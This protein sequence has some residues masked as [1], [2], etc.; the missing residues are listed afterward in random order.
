VAA[1]A[2]WHDVARTGWYVPVSTFLLGVGLYGSTSRICLQDMRRHWRTIL[3]AVTFGVIVKAALIAGVMLLAF[4]DPICIVLAMTVAQIDPLSV[5]AVGRRTGM[6]PPARS[7]LAAWAS[8]DDP[9]TMLLTLQLL[10]WII[11]RTD[12]R[13]GRASGPWVGGGLADFGLTLLGDLAVAAG[14]ALAWWLVQRTRARQRARTSVKRACD[15]AELI[16]LVAGIAVAVSLSLL[17]GLAVAG[18]FLRPRLLGSRARGGAAVDWSTTGAFY[19]AVVL[20]GLVSAGG[21]NLS[22]GIVLGAAAFG[23]QIVVGALLTARMPGDRLR[24][25]LAQQNGIT[26]ILL[27]LIIEPVVPGSLGVIAPAILTVNVLYLATNALA[28]ALAVRPHVG[29]DPAVAAPHGAEPEVAH[30][31]PESGQADGVLASQDVDGCATWAG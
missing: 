9:V 30:R 15:I 27:G 25:S 8:F 21:I 29:L 26:A 10:G 5:A 1:G 4:Q 24:L 14:L 18:L 17:L 13:G 23:A 12:P 2:G 19:L 7:L 20:L 16:L 31:I 3:T 11:V 22:R 28:D 6:S